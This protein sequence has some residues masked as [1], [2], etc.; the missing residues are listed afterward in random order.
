MEKKGINEIRQAFLEFFES[1]DHLV[2]PSFSLIPKDDNSLLLINS[3]MAPLKPFFAGTQVPP[4]NRMATSQKCIRTGDIENVGKTARHATFFEMLGNFS[5]GDYF[6]KE[7]IRWSWEFS[8]EHLKLPPERI[9][10]SIYEDDDEAFHLWRQEVGL[11]EERIVRLG[12]EDNF[13][14]IGLGPCGPCSELYFDR[15]EKY[16]C[17]DAACKPGCECDRYVEYWNLV[18]TQFNK[19]EAGNYTPLPNPN[20]DTGMGLERVACMLQEVDSIFEI[21]GMRVILDNVCERSGVTYGENHQ[22]DISIRIIT[23]HIRSITF[24]ISDGILPSN[25]GRGYVLRRLLR[26]AARHGKL[27]GLNQAFL[28][29]LMDKVVEKFHSG[30]PELM[31][32]QETIRKVILVEEDRFLETI[33]QGSEML[34]DYIEMMKSEG[35]QVL[36]GSQAFRLYDTFGFP[37]DLTK[38]ILEETGMTV[39]EPAFKAEMEQQKT[40][41]RNAR[42]E[43]GAV[44][45]KEDPLTVLTAVPQT[46]FVGYGSLA[47]SATVTALIQEGASVER[48]L[49]EKGTTMF[50]LLDQTPFYGEGGGQVGDQGVLKG[51]AF[52]GRVVDTRK[53][54]GEV[55]YHVVEAD[56]G[57][58]AVGDTLQAIVTSERRADTARNHTATHLLHKALK[59]ILGEHVQQ[60]G[61]LVTPERLRFDF[62]HFEP[63]TA[64]ELETV[65]TI[66][67][68]QIQRSLPVQIMETSIEKAR[69]LGAEAL[70]DA[71]YGE[72]VRV[73][74]TGDFS[75]ELC[76]GTHVNNSGEIGMLLILGESGIASGVRRIEAVTGTGA[77]RLFKQHQETL[78]TMA[79]MLK[80]RHERL[81]PRLD[82]MIQESREKDQLI[83][84][85]KQEQMKDQQGDLLQNAVT[86]GQTAVVITSLEG[87][88]MDALREL[89]DRIKEKAGSAAILL[90]SHEEDKVHIMATLSKDLVEKGLHAGKLVKEVAAITGGGGGGR[91]DMAQ[92]GG[93]KPDKI[94]EALS[95]AMEMIQQALA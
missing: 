3:G 60:A 49:A 69:S 15:G 8:L 65:E 29:Q 16:G 43:A 89:G 93:K 85:M 86:I 74:K 82:E 46:S 26:R 78:Q 47:V 17:G 10:A 36:S 94:P 61:S 5:F 38:E 28:Y 7:A 53:G 12:K 76:G 21:D 83:Q 41:A 80:T 25:E 23:D 18:F 24:M 34:G 48:G 40:R 63:M 77:Y 1:K 92:A 72:T 52:I 51:A 20:I 13:W 91:P 64:E 62:N 30:Y 39:D 14:E 66:V 90:A 9:W 84:K 42:S 32:K 88:S 11:P 68:Q 79:S 31:E 67:N 75:L 70:F 33:H 37:L 59:H 87:Q 95:R 50:V 19:D 44:G 35:Q 56:Q 58:I 4:K 57:Q 45:W 27:L 2:R 73:V 22:H 71:K 6:K 54:S 81:L 55:I